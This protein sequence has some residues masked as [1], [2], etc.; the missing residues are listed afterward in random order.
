MLGDTPSVERLLSQGVRGDY[1]SSR[2]ESGM[3]ALMWAAAEGHIGI[4]QALIDN[5]NV[6]INAKNSAGLSAIVYCFENIA[7]ANPRKAPPAGFPGLPGKK[8]PPQV[9]ITKKNTGHLGVAKIL[10]VKGADV[11]VKND[12]DE[13][14]LYL[15]AKKGQS[16]LVKLL[17]DR[18]VDVEAKSKGYGHTALHAAAIENHADTVRVLADVGAKVNA[19]NVVGWTSL[20]W[21]AARGNLEAVQALLDYGADPNIKAQRTGKSDD[22]S[23]TT[24]LQEGRKCEVPE[25]MSVLL[26]RGGANA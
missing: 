23:K 26:V 2:N 25:K 7:S 13:T 22:P 15:A 8:A 16:E 14:L 19:Q 18:G 21:A 10:M 11:N 9:K 4:V 20:I 5:G 1:Q 6:D 12:Y 3:T 17:A 24:A